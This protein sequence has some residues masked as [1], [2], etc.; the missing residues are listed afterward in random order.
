MSTLITTLYTSISLWNQPSGSSAEEWLKT[1][2]I[3]TQWSAEKMKSDRLIKV[4]M[5]KEREKDKLA[6]VSSKLQTPELDKE[7]KTRKER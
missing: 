2:G 3:D 1:N 7:K 6:L 5:L 4:I